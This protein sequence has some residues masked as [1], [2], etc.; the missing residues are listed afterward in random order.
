MFGLALNVDWIKTVTGDLSTAPGQAASTYRP[1]L[2][3]FGL[4]VNFATRS[5]SH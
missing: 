2:L 1:S 3:T 4:G 5:P